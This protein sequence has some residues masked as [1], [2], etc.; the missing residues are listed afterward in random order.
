VFFDIGNPVNRQT[1]ASMG[2]AAIDRQIA[3]C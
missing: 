3:S 1:V 2:A